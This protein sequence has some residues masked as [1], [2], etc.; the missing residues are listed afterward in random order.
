MGSRNYIGRVQGDKVKYIYCHSGAYLDSDSNGHILLSHYNE[1]GKVD[2][3]IRHGSLSSISDDGSVITQASNNGGD[4]HIFMIPLEQFRSFDDIDIETLYLWSD[5]DGWSVKSRMHMMKP[6][7]CG[8]W[9][10]LED[11]LNVHDRVTLMKE[12]RDNLSEQARKALLL[13]AE[14]K[15]FLDVYESS[16]FPSQLQYEADD[17][18]NRADL[19]LE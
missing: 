8:F 5:R 13:V 18:L 12:A 7:Q 15:D 16:S 17:L 19:L 14:F 11:V 6:F 2:E 3:L 4:V 9:Y 10:K 1:A